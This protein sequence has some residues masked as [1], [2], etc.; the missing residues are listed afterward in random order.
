M[1]KDSTSTRSTKRILAT[2]LAVVTAFALSMGVAQADPAPAQP[3]QPTDPVAPTQPAEPVAP[4]DPDDDAVQPDM[5]AAP[6]LPVQP[7]VGTLPSDVDPEETVIQLGTD[8]T[9]TQQ[10]FAQEFDRAMRSLAMRQGLPYTQETREAFDRFRGEFLEMYATHQALLSEARDRGIEVTDEEVDREIDMAR[11]SVGDAQFDQTI[12]DLGYT[13]LDD[14]RTAVREGLMAQRVADEFRSEIVV[15]D[16]ELRD[17][18]ETHRATFFQER[19]FDEARGDVEDRLVGE[20][21]NEQFRTLRTDR[22]I[23][24]FAERIAWSVNQN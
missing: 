5:P 22:G 11:Q 24:T 15:S 18:H 8:E 3:T 6:P 1:T 10:Q 21:L 12:L 20:R 13:G 16:D 9:V 23:E 7:G 17:Y 19:D 2:L 4:T 14:Y